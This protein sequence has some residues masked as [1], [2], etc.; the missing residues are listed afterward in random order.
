MHYFASAQQQEEEARLL[1]A[2]FGKMYMPDGWVSLAPGVRLERPSV[3]VIPLDGESLVIEPDTASWAFLSPAELAIYES[4]DDRPYA[5][6]ESNWP[7]HERSKPAEFVAQ[8][9]RR[10]LLLIERQRSITPSIFAD[11]ANTVEGHLVELLITEKCN[12]GCLYCLAGTSPNMPAMTPAV[13]RRTIDLAF[14][15]QDASSIAF[16]F[17]GGEPFLK[18]RLMQE[19]IVYIQNHPA[20]HAR[21]VSLHVQTNGTLLDSERVRWIKDN[22][23][24]LGL[25]LDGTP[26]AQNRSR[27]LVNGKESFSKLMAG[28]DLLQRQEVPFGALV[29][30]N[31]YNVGSVAELVDFLLDNGITSFK[32]NPV[33]YLGT[34]RNAWEDIGLT[35]SEIIQFFMQFMRLIAQE[36]YPLLEDNIRTMIEFLTSKKRRTRC[37]RSFCGA[38]DTFQAISANGDIYPCGRATQTPALKM[39][40]VFDPNLIRLTDAAQTHEIVMQIR[41]RRPDTL[42]DCAACPYRQLCQAGCSAQAFERYGTVRHKTPECTFYKTLYPHL[43]RWLSFDYL[44]FVRL[45]RS[46]YFDP[47]AS[48][49]ANQFAPTTFHGVAERISNA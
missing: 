36:G 48:L 49:Y 41:A 40:N 19:L 39:G 14:E 2:A 42:D 8:L 47:T 28:I 34:A 3:D 33:A 12:L 35:P 38:G 20:R 24:R 27:P 7:T 30:L 43:M 29:V 11:S 5:T 25:S 15:M 13:A 45:Q 6:F 32:L 23:I 17:S 26:D 31:R 21:P 18:Y 10:G 16:E 44:A 9:F 37:L 22:N 4:L 1:P 46:G